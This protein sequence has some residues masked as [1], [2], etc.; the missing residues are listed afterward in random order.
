MDPY[1]EKTSRS[2][3]SE[4]HAQKSRKQDSRRRSNCRRFG[5]KFSGLPKGK[6]LEYLDGIS[7]EKI[8]EFLAEDSRGQR[9]SFVL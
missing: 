2:R 7:A 3:M 9:T 8:Q 4:H 6:A 5:R 1:T